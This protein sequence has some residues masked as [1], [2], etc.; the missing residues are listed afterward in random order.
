MKLYHFT[1]A[2]LWPAIKSQGLRRGVIPDF[3]VR[4]LIPGFQWLT[5]NPSWDQAWDVS[6]LLPY[7]RNAVRITVKVPQDHAQYLRP[8]LDLAQLFPETAS[9]LNG[10]GDPENWFVFSGNIPRGWFRE[11]LANRAYMAPRRQ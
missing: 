8:W 3:G 7:R 5:R 6:H 9:I 11:V 2:H 4:R 10:Y 1:A